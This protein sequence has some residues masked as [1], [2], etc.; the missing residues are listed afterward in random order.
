MIPRRHTKAG[1]GRIALGRERSRL[2]AS[3]LGKV[4]ACTPAEILGRRRFASVVVARHAL[5][6]ELFRV[7]FS[8]AEVAVILGKDHTTIIHGMRKVMGSDYAT[9]LL[10]RY[11][12]GMTGWSRT[13]T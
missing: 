4:H 5:Y 11:P 13:T 8:I 9:E 10:D 12:Q 3:R 1:Q 7:G 6:V 2:I